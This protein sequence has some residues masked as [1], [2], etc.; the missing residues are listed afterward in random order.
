MAPGFLRAV[1]SGP[2]RGQLYE[3]PPA[4][5][6]LACKTPLPGTGCALDILLLGFPTPAELYYWRFLANAVLSAECHGC[7]HYVATRRFSH[8]RGRRNAMDSPRSVLDECGRASAPL[9]HLR[10]RRS[11]SPR[12]RLSFRLANLPR[13]CVVRVE[14]RFLTR[15]EVLDAGPAQ[16][17]WRFVQVASLLKRR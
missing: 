16:R 3:R 17:H 8:D 10:E 7:V 5:R 6:N 4:R 15:P 11:G 9:P 12:T 2:Q 1:A 13:G 14:S